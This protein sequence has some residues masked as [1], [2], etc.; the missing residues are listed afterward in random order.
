[1]TEETDV[2]VLDDKLWQELLEL[3]HGEAAPCFQCG[4]C[5]AICPW[6]GVREDGF[7]VRSI[8]RSAQT[9]NLQE[10]ERL[11]L[12]SACLQ[13]EAS[14]PRG[15]PI[16]EVICNL[17]YLL[18]TRRTNLH[19]LPA[20]L[21]SC[22]WN[23][24]PL[25]QPPSARMDWAAD[26]NLADFD[27]THHE[28]LLYFGC[29]LSYDR[30]AQAIA[31]A[32]VKILRSAG[33]SFGVLGL[34]EPCCGESVLRLGH[35]PFFAEL[36]Q[37]AI[38]V[39]SKRGITKLVVLSPHCFDVFRNHYQALGAKLEVKHITQFLAGL[40]DAGVLQF[41]AGEELQLTFHDPCLLGRGNGE[42]E[43]PR[44]ILSAIPGITLVPLIPEKEEGLC[45][46]GGGGRMYLE[47]PPGERFG[48]IRVQQARQTGAAVLATACPLCISCLEDSMK[49]VEGKQ[50]PVRDVVEIAAE[51]LEL[52]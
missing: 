48:D 30:R 9:G 13:C 45:C 44:Q 39:F 51:H 17:R 33:V 47:T 3:T 26:L 31:R 5:T 25:G 52:E 14:C 49:V 15:V 34:D 4:V 41:V 8:L 1:M 42:Y 28:W 43:A 27:P 18:W 37:Q 29:T 2:V 38:E 11:W 50:L 7:N 16:S 21:W 12:C 46:G 40:I 20:T 19:S 24:N 23:N 6:D 32:A 22:Y 36:A 35:A 10:L